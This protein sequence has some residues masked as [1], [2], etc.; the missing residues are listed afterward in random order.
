[1]NQ[2]APYKKCSEDIK[3][4]TTF[5]NLYDSHIRSD[6]ITEGNTAAGQERAFRCVNKQFLVGSLLIS[7]FSH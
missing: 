4:F 7:T 5:I 1:M 3:S 2:N 6:N